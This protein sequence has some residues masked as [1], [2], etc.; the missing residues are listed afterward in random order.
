MRKLWTAAMCCA[1]VA[2]V[3][4]PSVARAAY[5]DATVQLIVPYAAGGNLDVTA[6]SIAP[7][8]SKALGASVVILNKPG[9]G[10]S[11]GALYTKQAAANGYTVLVTANTELTVT[12][13]IANA[14]YSMKD[15]ALVGTIDTV[16]MVIEVNRDSKY[17]NFHQLLADACAKPNTV[18]VGIAGIGS[19]NF[20]GL[21]QLQEVTHCQF[22]MVPYTGS[23]PAL[24]GL[25]GHQIDAMIDQVSSSQS[26][27]KSGAFRPLVVMS[28]DK[29]VGFPNL[30]TLEDLGIHGANMSTAAALVVRAGTPD[31]IREKLTSALRKAMQDKQVD[32]QLVG[33]GGVPFEGKH[34]DF[35]AQIKPL[36]ALAAKYAAA[37]TLVAH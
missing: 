4:E 28:N 37:G 26:Y 13:H 3:A 6:R 7:A 25:M 35:M 33:L 23:G 8:L 17:Q 24:V 15:F 5:P 14:P 10:G 12:P 1:A 31:A 21:R 19:V 29:V 2:C 9:A 16:P 11:V 36:D 27:L 30:P 32:A 34:D 18:T 22:S 20:M